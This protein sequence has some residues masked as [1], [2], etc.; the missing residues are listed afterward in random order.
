MSEW[1]DPKVIEDEL[2]TATG[3]FAGITRMITALRKRK[4]EPEKPNPIS[5][6]QFT[7][8]ILEVYQHIQINVELIK[9]LVEWK[10]SASKTLERQKTEIA[11]LRKELADVKT[12]ATA[13]REPQAIHKGMPRKN[14]PRNKKVV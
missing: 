1:N 14:S 2:K 5:E 9:W 13:R 4:H 6:V 10:Q 7:E 12:I 3:L 8:G 11:E